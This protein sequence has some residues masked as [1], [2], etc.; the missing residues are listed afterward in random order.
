MSIINF[1]SVIRGEFPP[2]LIQNNLM[3]LHG[4]NTNKQTNKTRNKQRTHNCGG[5]A[6]NIMYAKRIDFRSACV[7]S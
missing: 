3:F 4:K 5:I 7:L 6:L 2:D 1:Y